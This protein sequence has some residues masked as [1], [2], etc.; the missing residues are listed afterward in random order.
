MIK[1]MNF[2]VQAQGASSV[3]LDKDTILDLDL[4]QLSGWLLTASYGH[5]FQSRP[6]KILVDVPP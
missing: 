4:D 6:T 1:T 5:D 2:F 3:I